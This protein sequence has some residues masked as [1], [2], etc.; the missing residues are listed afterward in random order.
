MKILKKFGLLVLLSTLM[1][2]GCSSS[3]TTTDSNN[4]SSMPLKG[5]TLNLY[6]WD[7]MF[8]QEVLDGFTKE[9]GITI[10][11]SNFDFDETMLAK[12]EETQGK[13]YDLVIADD[14]IIELAIEQGLV[15]KL[16]RTKIST[17]DNINPIYE[18]E[19]YDPNNEYTLPYGAGIPLIV[20]NPD[21]IDFEINGYS[22][23]WNP[24]LKDNLA[25]IGNYRV[26]NGI[27]LKSLGYLFNTNDLTEIKEAGDKLKELAPNIRIINDSNLQDFLITGEVSVAFMYT[28]QVNQALLTNPDFKVVYPEEGLGFGIMAAFI[29]SQAPNADAAYAFLDYIN[30]PEVAA[31]GFEW[32]GY[33][34]TNKAAEEYI[35]EEMKP[36][37]ILPE[38]KYD[39]IEKGEIIQNVEDDALELHTQIFAEFQKETK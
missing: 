8:P 31:K 27:A 10:N 35:S 37:I 13:D 14:Y 36:L 4:D 1:L 9:T 28:S 20:Y 18:N 3:N 16:D 25:I 2:S 19:F 38:D 23:L 29:P 12:L 24:K 34:V 5:T 22:D 21:E 32:L 6:T 17:I 26:I 33:F 11:Y 7:G 15:Q 39:L 30:R